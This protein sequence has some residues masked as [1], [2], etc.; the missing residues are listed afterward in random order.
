MLF[1]DGMTPLDLLD[2]NLVNLDHKTENYTADFYLGYLLNYPDDCNIVKSS[3][4]LCIG[5]ILGSH[6]DYPGTGELYSHVTVLSVAPLAREVSLGR[7]L[8]DMLECNGRA[9]NS[10]FVDLFV[11]VSNEPAIKFYRSLGYGEHK[12]IHNYYSSPRENAY[13]MRKYLVVGA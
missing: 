7:A 5:Y 8:M 2:L 13:D 11:R 6:G 12:N 4:G 9:F 1:V 3:T 10:V